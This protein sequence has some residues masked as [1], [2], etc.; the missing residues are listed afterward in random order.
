[1]NIVS[2]RGPGMAGGVSSAL[3]RL[4]EEHGAEA[5]WWHLAD[6]EVRVACGLADDQFTVASLSER[7]IKGHYDYCNEFIWPVMHDLPQ[8]ARYVPEHRGQYHRFNEVLGRL[9]AHSAL[10][11]KLSYFFVQ[12]YQLA[13]VPQFLKRNGLS[14]C[15]IFWHIPWPR[16][17]REDH[18]TPMVQIAKGLL[19]AEAVGF[20]VQEYG[21]NFLNFVQKHLP[22]YVV[23]TR[24]MTIRY[25]QY[26]MVGAQPSLDF[27]AQQRA[28]FAWHSRTTQVVI[29]PLGLDYEHWESMANSTR[30]SF[31]L[32]TL[33]RKPYILSVDRAD[34]TKGVSSRL[35]AIDTFFEKYPQWR[36]EVTF[37]QICGRTRPG[38]SSF[39]NYW[40][41]CKALEKRLQEKWRNGNNWSPLLWLKSSFSCEQLSLLYKNAAVMLVNP[42]RDGLNLTA[43]E[44]IACQNPKGGVLAL[45]RGAGAWQEIGE[46]ALEVN[47]QSEEQM[48]DTIAHALTINPDEKA[49]RMGALQEGVRANG[50][51]D[52]WRCFSTNSG[53]EPAA[54]E[55]ATGVALREIS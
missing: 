38:I 21:E 32:P 8:F 30:T 13:L 31:W 55:E 35:R 36:G 52:W 6:R 2:Y 11:S 28:N 20:H 18:V 49:I 24:L 50:L 29:A 3:A 46:H 22:E 7:L 37:A 43:K 51:E 14:R 33:Q 12:D 45:S 42:I 53:V 47:P 54:A 17:V 26:A 16:F 15:S 39:D 5:N 44:Y 41:E 19:N 10:S 25:P 48:A 40:S 4:W 27:A 34:Y 23:D 9:I 1:M